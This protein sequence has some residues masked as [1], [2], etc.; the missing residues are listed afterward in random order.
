L[1]SPKGISFPLP[2]E[3]GSFQ[4]IFLMSLM[5]KVEEMESAMEAE[6]RRILE[7]LGKEGGAAG[8]AGRE[9]R[10]E[11]KMLKSRTT[12]LDLLSD[13]GD[14]GPHQELKEL[15][16]ILN[17][18]N[19]LL[20]RIFAENGDRGAD[21][22]LA[23]QLEKTSQVVYLAWPEEVADDMSGMLRQAATRIR[24]LSCVF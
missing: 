9:F 1:F 19:A 6:G 5:S 17:G 2:P 7:A 12:A 13:Q 11:H 10:R 24:E 16:S 4:E 15:W 8:R 14:V 22:E 21:R 20:D 23:E 18:Q 3:G